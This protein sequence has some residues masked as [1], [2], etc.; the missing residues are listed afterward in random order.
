MKRRDEDYVGRIVLEMQLPGKIKWETP[1]RRH[2]DVVKE[3]MQE[4]RAREDE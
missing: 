4:V 2:F 1:K 3:D